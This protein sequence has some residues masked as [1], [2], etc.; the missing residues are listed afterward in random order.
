MFSL[1]SLSSVVIGTILTQ[2]VWETIP[3]LQKLSCFSHPVS[4]HAGYFRGIGEEEEEEEEENFAA[5]G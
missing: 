1:R 4:T 5:L 2:Q 3:K